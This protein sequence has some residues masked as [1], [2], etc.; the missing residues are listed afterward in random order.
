MHALKSKLGSLE[1]EGIGV[2]I[3]IL[4]EFCRWNG[5]ACDVA[6]HAIARRM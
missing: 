2:P 6:G 1:G 4:V 3:L 5:G